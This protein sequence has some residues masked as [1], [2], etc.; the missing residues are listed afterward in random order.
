MAS[1]WAV[2]VTLSC[3]H[4]A[5]TADR[6]PMLACVPFVQQQ[7]MDIWEQA[8]GLRRKGKVPSIADFEKLL[9]TAKLE[10]ASV[11][12]VAAKIS[13]E[14]MSVRWATTRSL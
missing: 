13:P 6:A 8:S 1:V 12:A 7:A 11:A 3:R 2:L 9:V 10:K 5:L 14:D 4:A